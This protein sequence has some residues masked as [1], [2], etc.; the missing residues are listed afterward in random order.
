M[1][2]Q[3]TLPLLTFEEQAHLYRYGGD[4]VPSVTQAMRIA[5][6]GTDYSAVPRLV[7][8]EASLDGRLVHTI[9][10]AMLLNP[11]ARGW[12]WLAE[13]FRSPRPKVQGCVRAACAWLG[14][15]WPNLKVETAERPFYSSAHGVAGTPDFV[16][17]LS[18]KR[19]LVDW[20]T[21][22]VA[23]EEGAG[24]QTAGY[25]LLYEENTGQEIDQRIMLHLRPRQDGWKMIPLTNEGDAATFLWAVREAYKVPPEEWTLYGAQGG[26]V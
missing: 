8:E 24:I 22:A 6:L 14:L 10:A 18:G 11:P 15:V 25:R 2:D 23:N 20:K 1:T 3:A 9:L 16:A 17:L 5:G 4:R 19:T 13:S 12:G 21:T 26:E 7:L